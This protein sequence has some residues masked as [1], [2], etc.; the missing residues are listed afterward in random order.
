[1]SRRQNIK[2]KGFVLET[3]GRAVLAFR[4]A[5]MEEAR[6]LC[7]QDWF[8]EELASYRS[9][10]HPIWDGT[11]ELRIRRANATESAEIQIAL[12]TELARKEYE[13]H[14]FVFFVPVDT[15]LQ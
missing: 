1:M 7:S 11:T 6:D 4:A 8:V 9:C 3:G 5:S 15:N 13:G 10:G 12:T 14:V 2:E